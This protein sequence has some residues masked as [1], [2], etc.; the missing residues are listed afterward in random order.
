MVGPDTRRSQQEG[1]AGNF[2][3]RGSNRGDHLIR[4]SLHLRIYS[5]IN[6]GVHFGTCKYVQYS[7]IIERHDLSLRSM[8]NMKLCLL[9]SAFYC[10]CG[11][12]IIGSFVS[13]CSC[14]C[15]LMIQ[16][17]KMSPKN[18]A[19]M[20]ICVWKHQRPICY[21]QRRYVTR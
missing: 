8:N 17:Y 14:C 12:T 9:T 1:A 13:F 16:F 19:K 2:T 15:L 18:T 21:L 3:S 11:N 6:A 10:K 4:G 5:Q 7:R 20:L